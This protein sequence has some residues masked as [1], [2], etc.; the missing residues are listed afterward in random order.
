MSQVVPQQ[1]NLLT[2]RVSIPPARTQLVARPRLLKR[3]NEGMVHKCVLI[4]APAGSGK[5]TLLAAWAQSRKQQGTHVA[6]LSLDDGDN[7]PRRFWSYFV[8]AL[9]TVQVD[10]CN[11]ILPL[12]HS[13]QPP[14][15]E[16]LLVILMN[17]L[18]TLAQETVLVLDDYHLIDASEVHR[19]MTVLLDHL[20][21]HVHLFIASRA[22]PPLPLARLRMRN[23]LLELR[24][25]EL[26]FTGEEAANFLRQTME[27][28]LPDQAV[29]ALESRT[30]G[31]IAGLQLAALSLKGHED[32]SSF[33]AAFTTSPFPHR[34]IADYLVQEVLEQQ[35]EQV[36]MFLLRTCI[37]DRLTSALCETLSETAHAQEMLRL[38][39]Q[40]NVFLVP[41]D[42][43]RI[44]YRYHQL[45]ADVLRSYV[46]ETMPELLPVLHRRA[47][48]WHEQQ[49]YYVEA[50]D[51]AIAAV[52][53][54]R[55]AELIERRSEAT[56]WQ[57]SD[58]ARLRRW[59]Q[60]LPETVI[61]AKPRLC[62]L[63]AS[64]IVLSYPPD[65]AQIET[66]EAYLR[67]A[68]CSLANDENNLKQL[69]HAR[70]QSMRGEI[71]AN[72]S[73]IVR[74]KGEIAAAR[75]YAFE[76]LAL[77]SRENIVYRDLAART[78]I[79]IYLNHSDMEAANRA[80]EEFA[81]LGRTTQDTLVALNALTSMATI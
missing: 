10:I 44:W 24:T 56:G 35:P 47:S 61:R 65:V 49:G 62:I 67:H 4:C 63:Y 40:R 13:S 48:D 51:H 55:A 43:Q 34:H 30:E 72:L 23:E 27:L 57:H 31:W 54:E 45:F 69:D 21:A 46:R 6:W 80:L 59:L 19:A 29:A 77:L 32:M 39:E 75:E 36:R 18:S 20:P 64:S 68:Q 58:Q 52:D 66:A 60:A 76:A 38:L 73:A 8:A 5:T 16:T 28:A 12:L 33:L 3:L 17:A 81:L 42:E 2:A 70:L 37:L 79:N 41:L 53:M 25:G 11:E 50:I 26:R 78:L 74:I 1:W 9:Q 7:D 14:P 15:F 71:M 22:D